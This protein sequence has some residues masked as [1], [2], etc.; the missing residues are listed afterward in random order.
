MRKMSKGLALAAGILFILAVLADLLSMA[1]LAIANAMNSGAMASV[2]A[3]SSL[4][5]ILLSIL[6][7]VIL[8]RRR[9]DIFAGVVLC[10]FG[11]VE[12]FD[13]ISSIASIVAMTGVDQPGLAAVNLLTLFGH[14]L[15][16]VGFVLMGV[17]CFLELRIAPGL[18]KA[19]M[20]GAVLVG[21]LLLMIHPFVFNAVLHSNYGPYLTTALISAATVLVFTLPAYVAQILAA[22]AVAGGKK[23]QVLP[24][25]YAQPWQYAPEQG[26]YTPGQGSYQPDPN[27][28]AEQGSYQP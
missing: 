23:E 10:L 13:V 27:A 1:V 24:P 5:G 19:L 11:L 15:L 26:S 16:L 28:S 7:A 17:E 18:K 14:L 3:L 6:A 20:G 12:L 25:Y 2:N 4:L 22:F 8:F 9:K 21:N